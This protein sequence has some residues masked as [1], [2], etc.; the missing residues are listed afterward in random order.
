M[1]KRINFNELEKVVL[2]L[3][4]GNNIAEPYTIFADDITEIQLKNITKEIFASPK[5]EIYQIDCAKYFKIGFNF[6]TNQ[7]K[8]HKNLF[9]EVA[10]KIYA[11]DLDYKGNTSDRYNICNSEECKIVAEYSPSLDHV[12]ITIKAD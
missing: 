6:D 7:I 4:E 1:E 5:D 9:E 8:D 2:F 3:N 11:I 12:L 10:Q